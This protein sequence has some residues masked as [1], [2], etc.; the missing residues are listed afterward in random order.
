MNASGSLIDLLVTRAADPAAEA[1]LLKEI[2]LLRAKVL[3]SRD[4]G[5][6]GQVAVAEN[7]VQANP[8]GAFT[9]DAAGF[10][11][12][13]VA[14]STWHSGR[15]E[16]PSLLTLKE[17]AQKGATGAR[18][19]LWVLDGA[20]PLTDIG[21]LQA[22]ADERVLFQVASQFN[23][24]ESPQPYVTRVASYFSD[25]TQGPRASISAFP[26]TLLRHYRAPAA[27]GERFVQETRGRQIDL[28]ADVCGPGVVESGYLMGPGSLHPAALVAAL[29]NGFDAIRVGVHD[30]AQVVLGASWYGGVEDSE[31][32]RIAQVFTSTVAGGLY[33]G[34]IN[35]GPELFGQACRSLLRAAYLGTCLAA[36]T[37]GRTRVVLTLIGGGVFGNPIATIWEAIQWALGA[38]EP[39]LARDLD[40]VVNGY[41]LGSRLDRAEILAAVRPRGG[42]M[43]AFAGGHRAVVHR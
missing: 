30:G 11:T 24:L 5:E 33:A 25:P 8:A 42:V 39:F 18:A 21:S 22:T 34:E 7:A 17:R 10:A 41:N 27:D 23:C 37:L 6:A 20:D 31:H 29:A 19:R 35:L 43:L 1:E 9:F 15:F 36:A 32:R 12:L 28:L 26:A 16:T 2:D 38:V 14:G 4:Q 3:A 13:G 40:V